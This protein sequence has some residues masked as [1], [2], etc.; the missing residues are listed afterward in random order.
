MDATF[1][2]TFVGIIS[3]IVGLI[4]IFVGIIGWNS[5]QTVKS[6]NKIKVGKQSTVMQEIHN[7]ISYSDVINIVDS[8]MDTYANS[9]RSIDELQV[10]L[11][12][13]EKYTIPVICSLSEAEYERMKQDGMIN[14]K[15]MYLIS[16]K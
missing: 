13:N 8:K 4:G 5:L 11:E 9:I 1:I 14:S 15:V 2:N 12:E 6:I 7:G 16:D 3:I 10:I